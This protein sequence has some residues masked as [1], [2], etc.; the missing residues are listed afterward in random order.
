M[1]NLKLV[2]LI[3]FCL[4]ST[5]LSAQ[6]SFFTPTLSEF[7]ASG[8]SLSLGGSGL[9]G[10]R[11]S[12]EETQLLSNSFG[13]VDTMYTGTWSPQ[14]VFHITGGLGRVFIAKN[15]ILA[16]RFSINIIGSRRTITETFQGEISGLDSL[17]TG[18]GS[19]INL[20][21][22]ANALKAIPITHRAFL[23]VGIGTGLRYDFSSEF[24]FDTST[25]LSG[26][27]SETELYSASFEFIT[28]GG[29]KLRRNKFLRIHLAADL[30]QLA[31]IN[32][33]AKLPW[34]V[35][36]YRPYRVIAV[37]D[38]FSKKPI[39][40]TGSCA[41]PSHSEKSKEL[42]GKKMRGYGQA[43]NKRAKKREE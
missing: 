25:P 34:R 26:I 5:F 30:L 2:I 1:P 11:S 24:D 19:S 28:G 38:F 13:V 3:S 7:R 16:D 23:E 9:G 29:I 17:L 22:Y 36:K 33:T 39:K 37:L 10:S 21:F 40:P 42:F 20:G 18:S 31:P 4:T 14:G 6:T 8:W 32:S 43:K 12:F 35:G 15:P 41:A 27:D